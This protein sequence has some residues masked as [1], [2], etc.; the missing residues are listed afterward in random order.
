MASHPSMDPN[1]LPCGISAD[2][3]KNLNED[4]Q[5]ADGTRDTRAA[6]PWGLFQDRDRYGH[7]ETNPAGKL[8]DV[9]PGSPL[10]TAGQFKCYIYGK[11]SHRCGGAA[12]S[13]P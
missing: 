11:G 5:K 2:E 7:V 8:H 6:C 12:Q 4:R 9:C 1:D 3:W 10:S 13:D